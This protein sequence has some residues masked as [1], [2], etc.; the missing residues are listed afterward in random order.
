MLFKKKVLI[1][2]GN[3]F[4]GQGILKA[5][6]KEEF[7][8]SVIDQFIDYKSLKQY[9]IK[10]L[11]KYSILNDKNL[12]HV[13][14]KEEWDYIIYLVAFRGNGNGLLKAANENFD[15]AININVSRFA[16]LLNRLKGI[17]VKVIWSSSSVVYGEETTYKNGTVK[18]NSV[19]KPSTNYGLTK[20]MAEKVANYYIKNFKMNITGIRLPI[21]IGPGL[22]YRGVAAGISDMAVASKTKNKCIIEI[23]SSPLDIIYIKDAANIFIK[24][25]NSQIKLKNIYNCASI[26]TSAIK[27]A[28]NFNYISKRKNIKINSISIG[29]SYPIM[30]YHILK[31]DLKFSLKYNISKLIKDWLKEI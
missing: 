25:M 13:L 2:G 1:I 4:L 27:L 24:I 3:G 17:K 16:Y 6:H 10:H 22:N 14:N 29:S 18:E 31:N 21:I 9:K 26:R 20:L 8:I 28:N 12:N 23:T 7:E 19:I 30:D 15:E 5:I 11:F